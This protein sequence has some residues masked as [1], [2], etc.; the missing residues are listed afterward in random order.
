MDGWMNLVYTLQNLH[1]HFNII[2]CAYGCR[3][4]NRNQTVIRGVGDFN[5]FLFHDMLESPDPCCLERAAAGQCAE[6]GRAWSDLILADSADAV[7]CHETWRQLL[8]HRAEASR[9]NLMPQWRKGQV[10]GAWHKGSN[11]GIGFERNILMLKVRWH[12]HL[13]TIRGFKS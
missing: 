8:K 2:R 1:V 12:P 6:Y 7:D 9:R 3:Y 5:W 11:A 13:Y 10:P 4:L